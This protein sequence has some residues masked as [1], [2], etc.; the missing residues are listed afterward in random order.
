[1]AFK[2]F[3]Q[4]LFERVGLAEPPAPPPQAADVPLADHEQLRPI[5]PRLAAWGVKRLHLIAGDEPEP[6]DL[7]HAARQAVQLGMQVSVRGRASDLDHG[8]LLS[9]LD[10]AA[11][12]V[13]EIELLLLS[14]IGEVHDALA[15][16]GDYRSALGAMSRLASVKLSLAIEIVL[17]PSTWKTIERTLQ[18]LDDRR[19]REVRCFAIAC[20]D[21]EPSSWAVSATELVAA[22]GWIE[23]HVPGDFNVTWYPPR[24]FDP[25]R[26]LADQVRRGPRAAADAV[27]IE[28]DGPVIPPTGPAVSA[29][30]VL[31]G[32]WKAIARSEVYRAWKRQRAAA[33]RCAECPGL[34]VCE[35]GCLREAA[36]W[37]V[38]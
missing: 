13:R 2:D 31:V 33:V 19:V 18:L 12:G 6:D 24:R 10:L 34:S 37:S 25:T 17:V 22:A 23:Q 15:G 1:M 4:N 30:N 36:N 16:A 29:G 3:L 26:S 32:D 21:D 7:V 9:D 20:R 5:F 35:K 11:A 28:P 14:A 27:R 38:G 8:K